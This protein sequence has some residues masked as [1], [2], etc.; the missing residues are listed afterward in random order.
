MEYNI[1]DVVQTVG[2]AYY[3]KEVPVGTVGTVMRIRDR[4]QG[5]RNAY[6]QYKVKFKGIMYNVDDI[7]H[8]YSSFALRKVE[9]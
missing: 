8:L 4:Y 6:K 3:D 7:N 2:M 9:S 1:G 5:T